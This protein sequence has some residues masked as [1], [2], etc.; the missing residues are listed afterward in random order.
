MASIDSPARRLTELARNAAELLRLNGFAWGPAVATG[1]QLTLTGALVRAAEVAGDTYVVEREFFRHKELEEVERGA[2]VLP[3]A[4][5]AGAA[6][7][8]VDYLARLAITDS[9]LLDHFGA[10]WE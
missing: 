5:A 2:P 7:A 3:D 4:F 1:T 10:A 9:D 8:Y 6:D